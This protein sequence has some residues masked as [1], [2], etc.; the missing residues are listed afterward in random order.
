MNDPK[1]T[2]KQ[3]PLHTSALES[4]KDIG[5]STAS[6]LK[7]DVVKPSEFIDQIIGTRRP[8][9]YSGE[10]SVGESL[11]MSDVLS[12]EHEEK[13]KIEK[14]LSFE[15]KIRIDEEIGNEKKINELK[16]QLNAIS[17]EILAIA[18]E[19]EELSE[20]IKLAVMQAPV[21][22][23]VYHVIFFEKLLEF[24]KSFRKKISEAHVW[25]HALNKR[26]QK[27]NAWGARY[28]KHGAKY[29]LSG[30]HYL[31]RSAG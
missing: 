11:E 12:G 8:Q 14:Q 9:K 27:K 29:L 19:T 30:E 4:L 13:K 15:R 2:K 18:V 20:D 5:T 1:K 31:S 3:K 22:P 6:S 26:A 10:I 21:E 23:G 16:M 24:I 25:L 17:K 28:K 7:K